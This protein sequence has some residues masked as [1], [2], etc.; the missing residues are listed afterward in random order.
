MPIDY[1]EINLALDDYD[2]EFTQSL[3]KAAETTFVFSSILAFGK[4]LKRKIVP[5]QVAQS[6]SNKRVNELLKQKI[7]IFDIDDI[8]AIKPVVIEEAP[9]K[10]TDRY[11]KDLLAGGRNVNIANWSAPNEAGKKTYLGYEKRWVP[12]LDQYK[13]NQRE[14]V[15]KTI[16]S[17]K[18]IEQVS[19]ELKKVFQQRDSYSDLVARTEVLNNSRII[20]Q[21]RWAEMGIEKYLWVCSSQPNSP[22]EETCAEFCGQIFTLDDIPGG[23]ELLHPNCILGN[24]K[25]GNSPDDILYITRSVYEGPVITITTNSGECITVTPNHMLLTPDGFICADVITKGDHIFRCS[26][27]ERVTL[28][29]DPDNNNCPSTIDEIF[30][31][32][33]MAGSMFSTTVPHSSEYFH[34][35]GMFGNGNVDIVRSDSL[36]WDTFNPSQI[37]QIDHFGFDIT[38]PD[39]ETLSSLSDITKNLKGLAFSSDRCMSSTRDLH[40]IFRSRIRHSNNLCFMSVSVSDSI[41]PKNFINCGSTTSGTKGN[42]LNRFSIIKRIYN[43]FKCNK[44]F[45]SF[46]EFYSS[47]MQSSFN[48]ISTTS[49]DISNFLRSNPGFVEIDTVINVNV[50]NFSGYVYDLQTFSTIYIGNNIINSNCRCS[51]SPLTNDQT[52][53]EW[54]DLEPAASSDYAKDLARDEKIKE[55]IQSQLNI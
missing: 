12:W 40:T 14:L 13:A 38:N 4:A 26:S 25:I 5:N 43:F 11:K 19:D 32:R 53:S 28:G 21:N 17:G 39:F 20:N 37:E 22:C 52:P 50:S 18:P 1:D 30:N 47:L 33:F 55:A 24:T 16:T 8:E 9:L 51:V 42:R 54:K 41:I 3:I 49:I 31:A 46:R 15:Y 23:G 48:N 44:W 10:F 35:D 7:P 34:G 27:S 2:N 45:N 29:V 36:L 6:L